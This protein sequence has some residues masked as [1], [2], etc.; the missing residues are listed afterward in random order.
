MC[1]LAAFDELR[2]VILFNHFG[3]FKMYVTDIDS[4]VYHRATLSEHH[5]FN[6]DPYVMVYD[7]IIQ[8]TVY[9]KQPGAFFDCSFG[10]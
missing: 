3:S 1:V 2:Q 7:S 8:Y 10:T 9:P 5:M 6:R 4:Y